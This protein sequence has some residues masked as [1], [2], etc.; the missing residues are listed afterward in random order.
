MSLYGLFLSRAAG[1]TIVELQLGP[2]A[3]RVAD[4]GHRGC[5]DHA[6]RGEL[7]ALVNVQPEAG[8][9]QP[10]AVAEQDWS[11]VQLEFVEQPGGQH[12]AQQRATSSDGNVLSA[13]GV[14]GQF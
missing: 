12:P 14:L 5:L 8:V 7:D 2:G 11:D 10:H 1:A 13:G 9:K 6:D 3:D 4:V